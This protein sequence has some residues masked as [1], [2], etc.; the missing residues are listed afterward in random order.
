M[1]TRIS[2][3]LLLLGATLIIIGAVFKLMHLGIGF[4][5]A[6]TLVG[7]GALCIVVGLVIILVKRI[8]NK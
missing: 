8:T 4:L 2:R 7:L 5:Q 1:K 6:N 3:L